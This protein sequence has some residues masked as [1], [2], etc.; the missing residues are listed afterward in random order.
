M[1]HPYARAGVAEILAV[2][3]S[4]LMA[5]LMGS[6]PEILSTGFSDVCAYILIQ[7]TTGGSY[8]YQAMV[9]TDGKSQLLLSLIHISLVV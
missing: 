4:K 3:S 5:Q 1:Y 7:D 6:A 2:Q 8:S 9:I